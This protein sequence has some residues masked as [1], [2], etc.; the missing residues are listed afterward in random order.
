MN[1]IPMTELNQ[2]RIG[3]RMVPAYED[4]TETRSLALS[5]LADAQHNPR[6]PAIVIKHAIAKAFLA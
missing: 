3:L 4:D 1:A 2:K 5:S 6:T